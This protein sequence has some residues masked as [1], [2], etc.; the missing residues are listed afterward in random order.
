MG[1]QNAR[2]HRPILVGVSIAGEER[3]SVGSRHPEKVAGLIYLDA[4]YDYAYHDRLRGS[5]D[6]DALEVQRKLEQLQP[7]KGP[8]DQRPLMHE[9]L[10]DS[11]PQLEKQLREAL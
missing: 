6:L 9:L 3:S 1:R 8:V 10:N 4:G 2:R 7:G 11:L 5:L